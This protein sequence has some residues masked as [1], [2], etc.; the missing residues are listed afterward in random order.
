MSCYQ[1]QPMQAAAA[2]TGA[3]TVIE[4]T[5]PDNGPMTDVVCQVAGTFVGTVQ[6]EATINN[7]NWIAVQATNLNSGAATTTATAAGLYRINCKGLLKVR[8]NI[9]AY[10]S[11]AITVTGLAVSVN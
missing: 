1:M 5:H 2:A 3:G 7:T 8:A 10:T 4:T 11:G 6:F 9:T